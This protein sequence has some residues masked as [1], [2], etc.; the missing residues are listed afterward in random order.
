MILGKLSAI[1][2]TPTTKNGLLQTG[3]CLVP[4]ACWLVHGI[5]MAEHLPLP[6]SPSKGRKF[7]ERKE[8]EEWLRRCL[9]VI[10]Q[11]ELDIQAGHPLQCIFYKFRRDAGEVSCE[12]CVQWRS[13]SG[14]VDC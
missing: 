6:R 14:L 12:V 5:A 11:P 7:L 8:E 9:P 4:R 10:V 3:F 1:Y 2:F 13:A